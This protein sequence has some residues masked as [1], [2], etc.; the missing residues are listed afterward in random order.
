M[1][2]ESRGIDSR[3]EVRRLLEALKRDHDELAALLARLSSEW[4]EEDLVYRFWHRSW[5]VYWIQDVTSTI[6]EALRKLSPD[7][8]PLDDW[9]EQLVAEGTG[10]RFSL[11]DNERWLEVTRPMVEAYFHARYMLEMAVRYGAEIEDPPA[12]MPSGW[13]ALL[14]LYGLR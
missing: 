7:H 12:L 14:Y 3:P 5:K 6:A 13:A 1:V 9:F 11:D 4:Y 2:L 10:R 8:R